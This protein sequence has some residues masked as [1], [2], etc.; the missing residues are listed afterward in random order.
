M[1]HTKDRVYL[2][3]KN[4]GMPDGVH[5]SSNVALLLK[6]RLVG[7]SEWGAVVDVARNI[8]DGFPEL[9]SVRT[10]AGRSYELVK[11]K[12]AGY[13]RSTHP[14]KVRQNL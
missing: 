4:Q 8:V 12:Q 14:A 5:L 13:K 6:N 2:V 11:T 9:I 10:C 7:Q 3:L 1:L